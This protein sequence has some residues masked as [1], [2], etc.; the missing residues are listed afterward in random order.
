MKNPDDCYH[1]Q[2]RI[3]KDIELLLQNDYID[4]YYTIRIARFHDLRSEESVTFSKYAFY[5]NEMN[6]YENQL[7]IMRSDVQTLNN[8]LIIFYNILQP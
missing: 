8:E 6:W 1:K 4:Q 7:K 5:Q 2:P 3:D